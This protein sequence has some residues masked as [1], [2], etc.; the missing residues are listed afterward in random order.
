M[1]SSVQSPIYWSSRLLFRPVD[2]PNTTSS[3]SLSSPPV[4]SASISSPQS[5]Q[6]SLSLASQ[7]S[8]KVFLP[9]SVLQT[10]LDQSGSLHPLP[11]PLTFKIH[12][13]ITR[14]FTHVG[15]REFSADEGTCSIPSVIAQRI[16]LKGGQPVLISLVELPK[17]TF[18]SLEI[19]TPDDSD[20]SMNTYNQVDDWKA[21]LEAQLQSGY[22]ALTKNDALYIKDPT[23]PL[24]HY[25]GIVKDL[26][27]ADAV[28]IIDTDID[29]DIIPPL[30]IENK[31]ESSGKKQK[32]E[33]NLISKDT[34]EPLVL[35]LS[36]INSTP[37]VVDNLS[38]NQNKRFKKFALSNWYQK[39]PLKI[40]I[41][42][43]TDVN[44]SD[45]NLL[46]FYISTSEYSIS[47]SEF[48][49]SSLN[50]SDQKEKHVI[51]QPNDPYLQQLSDSTSPTLY[52][53]VS[54]PK[55]H[56]YPTP[57]FQNVSLSFSEDIINVDDADED[58]VDMTISDT[59]KDGFVQCENCMQQVPKGSYQ[60]HLNFCARNNVRC[61][62]GCNQI[63]SRRDTDA[64]DAHWHCE[65]CSSSH[66]NDSAMF[67]GNS[68]SSQTFHNENFHIKQ[69]CIACHSDQEFISSSALAHHRAT[70]CSS[71]LHIC[72][73]CHLKLPQGETT[74]A[75]TLAGFT[76]HESFCGGKT[77]DCEICH[78]AVRLRDLDSH[79]KIHDYQRLSNKEPRN[80]C[81]NINCQRYI[82]DNEFYDSSGQTT[83]SPVDIQGRTE[84]LP[85]GLCKICYGPLYNSA[86]DPSGAK[87]LSRIERKY[88]IQLT[89][90]CGKSF[91][92]NHEACATSMS[93][94]LKMPEVMQHVREFMTLKID[95]ELD[96]NSGNRF[97]KVYFCVDETTTK[98]K[99]FVDLVS[100]IEQLYSKNW[101]AKAIE[102]CKGNESDA[103]KWLGSNA[104]KLQEQSS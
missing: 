26:K 3:S 42:I 81:S 99:M 51:I 68:K 69:R 70:V 49:W 104:I 87:L 84:K 64:I 8:D 36:K 73:F 57:T 93:T 22:T 97:Q 74:P 35:D 24:R 11:S 96:E 65:L 76:G 41:S 1:S 28:L 7:F 89:K 95:S 33:Q 47:D 86:Y 20:N 13:P 50:T 103:R 101:A 23:N 44:D 92:N 102:V 55:S 34:N 2:R 98:R 12:N 75:D 5:S 82:S 56:D 72:R 46:N 32:Y 63:F 100:E 27:P 37:E 39:S 59:I 71:K 85:Y 77:T 45:P 60:L 40:S 66:D 38:F 9:Q 78:K 54:I 10:L 91:C 29:L 31:H 15:V 30:G 43:P 4:L 62:K 25:K 48:L 21:L 67:Y 80:I 19:V 79:L 83:F 17:A 52:C 88:V 14:Q 94:K 61:T 90:G 53:I 6:Q 16:G 18:L 58:D